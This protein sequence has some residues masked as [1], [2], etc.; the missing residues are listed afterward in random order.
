MSKGAK[1]GAMGTKPGRRALVLAAVAGSCAIGA[2][3]AGPAAV[4]VL[5]PAGAR[6]AGGRWIPTLRL[7]QLHEG[8]PKRAAIVEDRRDAWS[9]ERGV[10]LG[11]IWLV[12][13][14]DDVI[15]L[16][17]VCPHLG[18]SVNAVVDGPGGERGFACPCH[19]SAF[20][21]DGGRRGG[22]SPRG[23]DTLATRIVRG[24]VEVDFRRF[25][26]G[27]AEKEEA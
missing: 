16:S 14:G 5:A 25:R 4:L 19:T 8:E 27:I 13:R 23:M 7:D 11:S 9:I 6:G 3:V 22:P 10:E 1:D 15:A 2:A 12:R 17:A 24:V 18:C 21:L 20:G 26:I